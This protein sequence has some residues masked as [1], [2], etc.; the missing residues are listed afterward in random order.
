MGRLFFNFKIMSSLNKAFLI[1]NISLFVFALIVGIQVLPEKVK[2]AQN[3]YDEYEL[4]CEE[5]NDAM[6]SFHESQKELLKQQQIFLN[7]QKEFQQIQDE[8]NKEQLRSLDIMSKFYR[9][10]A[11]Y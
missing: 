3:K 6:L 2:V 5:L 8:F 1:A 4:K 11:D 10:V 7:T 9:N